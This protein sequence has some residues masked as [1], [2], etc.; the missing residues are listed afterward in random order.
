MYQCVTQNVIKVNVLI[1]ICAND[2]LGGQAH[3]V[4]KLFALTVRMGIVL[5]LKYVIVSMVI[6]RII[7]QLQSIQ[8]AATMEL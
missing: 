8:L 5:P 3:Y 1:R 2:L 7:A 6:L 4:I